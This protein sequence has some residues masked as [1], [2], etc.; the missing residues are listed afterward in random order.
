VPYSLKPVTLVSTPSESVTYLR[1]VKNKKMES[2]F[3]AN[4]LNITPRHLARLTS[5]LPGL[6]RYT[7]QEEDEI[8]K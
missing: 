5:R 3:K 1:G 2:T 7:Y 6:M 8:W 4:N